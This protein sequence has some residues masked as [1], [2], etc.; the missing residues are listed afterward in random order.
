MDD[1]KEKLA[2]TL[3]KISHTLQVLD[4][5]GND[6]QI[7]CLTYERAYEMLINS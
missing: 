5:N 3:C 2:E 7:E 1:T 4:E 6:M